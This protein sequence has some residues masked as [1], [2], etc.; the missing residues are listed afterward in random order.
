MMLTKGM[1]EI[2]PKNSLSEKDSS[3]RNMPTLGDRGTHPAEM[4]RL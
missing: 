2:S 3:Y 1:M 4:P